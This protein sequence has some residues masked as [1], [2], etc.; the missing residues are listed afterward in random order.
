[1]SVFEDVCRDFA[2]HMLD[3]PFEP[4]RVGRWWTRTSDEEVDVVVRGVDDELFVGECKWGTVTGKDLQKLKQRGRQIAEEIGDVPDIRY[5]VFSGRDEMT[6]GIEDAEANGEVTYFK[7]Q[8]L[9]E[10]RTL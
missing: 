1:G 7:G 6:G 10:A 9:F 5:G 2:R 8:D 4:V 3:L